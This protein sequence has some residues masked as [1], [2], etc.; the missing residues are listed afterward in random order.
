MKRLE[1]NRF[2]PQRDCFVD[3]TLDRTEGP[4]V[5]ERTGILL[6]DCIQLRFGRGEVPVGKDVNVSHRRTRARQIR[7]ERQCRADG[8]TS[9]FELLPAQRSATDREKV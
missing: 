6:P 8:G 3:P 1:A 7:L 2:L 4:E 9:F 5:I